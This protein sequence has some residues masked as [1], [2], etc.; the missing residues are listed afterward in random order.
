MDSGLSSQRSRHHAALAWHI[1]ALSVYEGNLQDLQSS[2]KSCTGN[3]WM[4]PA[5][6]PWPPGNAHAWCILALPL[7][8]DS[9]D[10][11]PLGISLCESFAAC[12]RAKHAG[13]CTERR[14]SLTAGSPIADAANV[15][16]AIAM[17]RACS[18]SKRPS[19]AGSP[20]LKAPR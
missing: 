18:A 10:W 13:P 7:M 12:N 2:L 5:Q 16:D 19:S 3:C 6:Q 11:W 4:H 1:W 17:Q 15:E 9:L 14:T 20:R 8:Y